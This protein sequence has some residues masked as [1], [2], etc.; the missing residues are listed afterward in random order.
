M[1]V[2]PESLKKTDQHIVTESTWQNFEI[3]WNKIPNF[4]IEQ[5]EKGCSD[6]RI[7]AEIVHMVV[8]EMRQIK[9]HIPN[10]AYRCIARKMAEK[11][12]LTFLD[13]DL[14]GTVIGNGIHSIVNRLQDRGHYLNRP[15][16]RKHASNSHPVNVKIARRLSNS[17]A[18]CSNW[19][20]EL[21]DEE[22]GLNDDSINYMD[23]NNPNFYTALEKVFPQQR[24]FINKMDPSPSIEDVRKVWGV[25]FKKTA[26]LW[27]FTKLTGVECPN[28][29]DIE[30]K[31]KKIIDYATSKNIC[32]ADNEDCLL[33]AMQAL[34]LHFKE[35]FS[36]FLFKFKVC[37]YTVRL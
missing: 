32:I 1:F 12:P 28:N 20:P 8:N 33:K 7:I 13:R 34:C 37:K 9:T 10:M 31:C 4:M 30:Q 19:Q 11:F 18:G 25:L 27:H 29:R 22:Q 21:K 2:H 3:P 24:Q 5:C 16:K 6:R 17:M 26:A 14:D 23:E 36:A 15:H 35:N